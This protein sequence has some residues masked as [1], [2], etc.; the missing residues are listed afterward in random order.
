MNIMILDT[1]YPA[2]LKQFSAAHPELTD[3]NY[4]QRRAILMAAHF[5]EADS[6]SYYLGK[7]GHHATEVI[8]NADF[9]QHQWA[10]EHGMRTHSGYRVLLEQVKTQRPDV[11]Y[12]QDIGWFSNDQLDALR[13]HVRLMA[14]QIASPLPSNTDFSAFTVILS[15]FP[16]F[17]RFFRNLGVPSEYLRL[18]FDP[19]VLEGIGALGSVPKVP[20]AFVGGI[21]QAHGDSTMVLEIVA[22]SLPLQ[23][24]GYGAER[25]PSISPLRV[26]HQGLAW[27]L[28]MYRRLANARLA[29]NRH[30]DVAGRFANN[31]R[32]YEATGI[33]SCLVTDAKG[34]LAELFELDRE[35]VVY[36]SA[37]ECVEKCQF[38][39]DHEAE[40]AAI[41]EAGQKRTL[42]EHNYEHRMQELADILERYLQLPRQAPSRMVHLRPNPHALQL[43][44]ALRATAKR[45]PAQRLIRAM[46]C[47]LPKP[48]AHGDGVSYGHRVIGVTEITTDLVHGWQ[49]PD[50]APKQRRLVDAQLRQMYQG[51][52][53][54]VFSAASEAVRATDMARG[55]L[56]EV[57]CA[58]GYY[59][60]VLEHLLRHSID[61]IGIDYSQPLI[62]LARRCYPDVPF[63]V[64]DATHLPL[65]DGSCD[66][67]F[68]G[69]VLLHVP[70]YAAVIRESS[71]VTNGWC[72]FHRTP[73]LRGGETAYLSKFAYGTEVVE[74]AF[75]EIELRQLFEQHSLKVEESFPLGAYSVKGVSEEVMMITYVCRKMQS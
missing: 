29:L 17:V 6:Y 55:R 33:G 44:S 36:E 64:G 1:Y 40:R 13:R 39:L 75:G 68:S 70:D 14:G 23:V 20:V 4:D 45:L 22:R 65:A 66:I 35:V 24:W 42:R 28:D 69:T 59:S 54:P 63:L 30:I 2:F 41:A 48:V 18:A 57:G 61:Y 43:G 53:A 73:V 50:I 60:E 67:L 3:L 71:R 12:I 27:G 10:R 11:L 72:I 34:N 21:T 49:S 25:L 8:V 37:E 16:H 74:L 32:L 56:V 58:S 52:V 5:A 7:L 38:L 62:D 9:L 46:Y 19:R 31:L 15:S 26:V 47:R 51:E